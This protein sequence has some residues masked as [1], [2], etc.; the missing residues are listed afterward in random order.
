MQRLG[1]FLTHFVALKTVFLAAST[2]FAVL[3]LDSI[4]IWASVLV[5]INL[6]V[7]RWI[8]RCV[9]VEG[10]YGCHIRLFLSRVKRL[11]C[12][13]GSPYPDQLHNEPTRKRVKNNNLLAHDHLAHFD[14]LSRVIH[15]PPSLP[16][17]SQP[18]TTT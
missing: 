18:G 11:C 12:P 16:L 7:L 15:V 8:L 17:A 9:C 4:P 6:A 5:V 13:V 3:R 1:A 14:C 10:R 2:L